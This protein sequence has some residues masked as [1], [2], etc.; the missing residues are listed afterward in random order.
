MVTSRQFVRGVGR[1]MRAMDRAAKQAER[2]RVARQR[3]L[4]HQAHLDASA[5]A[6]A[7][8]EEI[9][10]VLTGAHRV[11]LSRV[12]WLATATASELPMPERRSEAEDAATTRLAEYTPGWFARTFGREQKQRD[13]LADEV[14]AAQACD[15][16]AHSAETAAAKARNA[17]IAVA[18]RV[19][20]R[21][22][23]AMVAVLDERSALGSLPFSVEGVDTLLLDG[24]TIAIVDG[25]NLEDM[26]E[27][28]VTL[29]KSGKASVK[30]LAVGKRIEMHR[31]AICSAA[32][33]VALEYLAALP[34]DEVE[35]LMLTDILDRGSG[36]IQS[37]PVLHLRATAQALGSLNLPRTQA[38]AVIERLGAHMEWSKRVGFSAINAAAFGVEL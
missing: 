18:R 23:D 17:E 19:V 10:E 14:A 11:P 37:L 2:Q 32:I 30:A 1:T 15:D 26:P 8:Y 22:P 27:E 35:V 5:R 38:I 21:D 9:V 36:H 31:D 34:I 24:R 3:A 4:H 12:D 20:D 13:R 16:A 29:L 28:I 33:R 7:E 6:A 25:L